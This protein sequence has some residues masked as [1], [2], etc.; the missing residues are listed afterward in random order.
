MPK[1]KAA[2]E[3]EATLTWDQALAW[4]MRR[5]FLTGDAA[6]TAVE[7]VDRL[8]GVQAQVASSAELAVRLRLADPETDAVAREISAGRLFK[9]WAMRGT[10]HLLTP[11]LGRNVLALMAFGR[12]WERPS[13]TKYFGLTPSEMEALR[14]A[15]YVVLGDGPM[16]R[17][18]L[19]AAV[20]A[21]PGLAHAGE[22]LASGWGTLLK[23]AAWC[24][25][26][27]FG[28]TRGTRVTFMRTDQA[29]RGW[30]GNP[31]PEEAAPVAVAAYL[32]TYGPSTPETFSTWLAG[33]YFSRKQ[34]RTWFEELGDRL[35]AVDVDGERQFVLREDLGRL[36]V[37]RPTG[38]VRFVGGFDQAVLG[39]TTRDTHV[40]AAARRAAVSRTAGWIAPVVLVDGRVRGTWE[41][42]NGTLAVEW[43]R[44][45]GRVPTSALRAETTRI[46]AL[47]DATLE[48]STAVV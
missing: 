41:A 46:A 22:Q 39:P 23:P 43:F 16:S 21:R 33:G 26:L 42:R 31:A 35:A 6:G 29:A 34:L 2:S 27:A 25:L 4:R 40:L 3:P 15:I 48:L 32:S 13:W 36:M 7:V 9:T 1:A 37:G 38:E 30:R 10:L 12:S 44:E 24:G 17:E 14:N 5:Q 19:I 18:E 45:G 47:T 28:P 20:T 8:C 11:E